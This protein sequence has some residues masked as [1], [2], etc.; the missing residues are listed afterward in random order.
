MPE[1]EQYGGLVYQVQGKI[2][3]IQDAGRQINK[4]DNDFGDVVQMMDDAIVEAKKV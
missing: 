2:P 1:I 4:I 3:E